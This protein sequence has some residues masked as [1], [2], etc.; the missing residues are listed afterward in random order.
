[1]GKEKDKELPSTDDLSQQYENL[2]INTPVHTEQFKKKYS[3]VERLI[4]WKLT[5]IFLLCS[6]WED[7]STCRWL[8]FTPEF[9][10]R[11]LE[12][13]ENPKFLS[14]PST[15]KNDTISL[16]REKIEKELLKAIDESIQP[17]SIAEQYK[18]GVSKFLH[19]MK[20]K[21]FDSLIKNHR[22]PKVKSYFRQT[23]KFW[24]EKRNIAQQIAK[25]LAIKFWEEAFNTVDGE[26]V[27]SQK[28]ID[29]IFSLFYNANKIR[30]SWWK[31]IDQVFHDSDCSYIID[32]IKTNE[33]GYIETIRYLMKKNR[34][35]RFW[36]RGREWQKE[37]A[38]KRS[39][40]VD[41]LRALTDKQLMMDK[42]QFSDKNNPD[43]SRDEITQ[44][45]FKIWWWLL[46]NEVDNY[47]NSKSMENKSTFHRRLKS[48]AS[49]VEKIIE[50]KKINDSIWFR[51]STRWIN[52]NIYWDVKKITFEWLQRFKW[53]LC[54]HPWKYIPWY[55]KESWETVSI[56]K[57]SIDNKWV[58]TERQVN[59][60]IKHLNDKINKDGWNIEFTKR[61]LPKSPYIEKGAWEGR[62]RKF[63]PEIVADKEMRSTIKEFYRKITE[64]VSRWKNWWYKD[65]KYNITV[66][67]KD[68]NGTISERTIELQ[69][70]DINNGKGLSNFNIRNFERWVNTQ[71]RLSFSVTLQ[72]ARKDCEKRLKKMWQWVNK[73][74]IPE[75]EKKEFFQIEFEDTPCKGSK[76]TVDISDFGMRTDKNSDRI[77]S[78]IINI[79]NY[80]LKKWTFVLCD[81][82]KSQNNRKPNK[83]LTVEDLQDKNL[84]ENLHICSILELASQQHSYLHSE[85]NRKVWIYIKDENKIKRIALWK[86]INPMNLWKK[87]D[88][89]YSTIS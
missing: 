74:N 51:I 28:S 3:D 25:I 78:A 83:L 5:Q 64:W 72:D 37:R 16:S 34:K 61:M 14:N 23:M 60:L 48:I 81:N 1:M 80:F 62:M 19:S 9:E 32:D 66:E 89:K 87:K 38:K 33:S 35:N 65:F 56:K 6:I 58:L 55:D 2:I 43:F 42:I 18:R 12:F 86:L 68:R 84:M 53:S 46:E 57:V 29:Y 59:D 47:N 82:G 11:E 36:R 31:N 10:I 77:N 52:N 24:I 4:K 70:D 63:Y 22:W 71:S 41:I 45:L 30:K 76:E 73:L 13:S 79:I 7:D 54:E 21:Y 15:I 44:N 17:I 88:P 8:S 69:F 67:I 75:G 20:R 85:R 39:Q 26:T 40:Y 49:C 50:G 27:L